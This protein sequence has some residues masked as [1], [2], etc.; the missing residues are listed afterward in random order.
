M[1]DWREGEGGESG[2][3]RREGGREGGKGEREGEGGRKQKGLCI[4]KLFC[5]KL[6]VIIPH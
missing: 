2:R 3:E 6:H 5:I 1:L 4:H